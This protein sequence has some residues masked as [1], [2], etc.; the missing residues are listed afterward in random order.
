M[1][2]SFLELH[3][4]Q[5]SESSFSAHIPPSLPISTISPLAHIFHSKSSDS[6]LSEKETRSGQATYC[7]S[8]WSSDISLTKKLALMKQIFDRYP[9]EDIIEQLSKSIT[10]LLN[11]KDPPIELLVKNNY[12]K[13]LLEFVRLGFKD[14][15]ISSAASALSKIISSSAKYASKFAEAHGVKI[16]TRSIKPELELSID[17]VILALANLIKDD[18]QYKN[19]IIE[20]NLL[21]ILI[22]ICEKISKVSEEIFYSIAYFLM[23]LAS[24]NYRF[25]LKDLEKIVYLLDKAICCDNIEIQA[26]CLWAIAGIT[27]IN[28]QIHILIES[29]LVEKVIGFLKSGEMKLKIPCIRAIRYIA[30][31]NPAN[32][33]YLLEHNAY[34]PIMEFNKQFKIIGR[35]NAVMIG[36]NNITIEIQENTREYGILNALAKDLESNI[37]HMKYWENKILYI[38]NKNNQGKLKLMNFSIFKEIKIAFTIEDELFQTKMLEFCYSLFEIMESNEYSNPL[39]ILFLR[40]KCY[41][42]LK[43]IIQKFKSLKELCN[44][45]AQKFFKVK[46]ITWDVPMVIKEIPYEAITKRIPS[47]E[48]P[49]GKR[50][51]RPKKSK[52]VDPTKMSV[53]EVLR[54]INNDEKKSTKNQKQKSST[55]EATDSK[56]ENGDLIDREVEEFKERIESAVIKEERLKPKISQEWLLKIKESIPGLQKKDKSF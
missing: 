37:S 2:Q 14:F 51:T 13:L 24:N 10:Q 28:G 5:P 4:F 34:D 21:D 19:E 18:N 27:S 12:I 25:L 9:T 52:T 16:L 48:K 49:K 1:A 40:S 56:S 31:G 15:I 23:N 45:I 46:N 26:N 50:K 22:E 32:I 38:N 29:G 20:F 36:Y 55:K 8:L 39:S 41:D 54:F 43:E 30:T 47:I 42:S 7:Q 53:D 33:K 6:N 11:D 44:K 17:A 3:G 35:Q